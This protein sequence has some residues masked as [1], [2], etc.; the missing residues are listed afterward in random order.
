MKRLKGLAI[1]LVGL[2]VFAACQ[3]EF[4]YENPVPDIAAEGTLQG[5]AG[6]CTP[7]VVNGVYKND[8]TLSDS[9][10]VEVQINITSPGRYII[11]TDLQNGFAF[12]DSGFIADTGLH[13]FTLKA[14]GKPVL[15]QT[16]NFVV[17]FDSTICLFSVPVI[18]SASATY[19]LPGSPTACSNAIA[20]G[21]YTAGAAL[22]A[23]NKVN[24]QVNVVIPGS[25]SINTGSSNGMTF[26]GS[27]NFTTTGLQT[28]VLQGSG[29]APAAG[30]YTI[31][32]TA[33]STNCSFNITVTGSGGGTTNPNISDTA[34]SFTQGAN[35]FKGP[36]FDVFDTTQ[37]GL[38]YGVVFIGYTPAT[39][40]TLLQIGVLFSGGTIQPGTYNTN[41]ISSAFYFNDIADTANVN[42]I[43]TADAS[44]PPANMQ[45]TISSYDQTTG[46][47]TGTFTGTALNTLNAP[48]PITLGRFRGKVR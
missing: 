27:G 20:E 26:S 8:S 2:F 13:V 17:S 37:L 25:Y 42:D 34:W 15:A 18:G 3:K 9:N 41:T 31:P 10:N 48:V 45:I 12:R 16:T 6:N 36:F 47:I 39:A 23:T 29:R 46:I 4:S 14:L 30:V 44:T 21:I 7:I 22:S 43:Y 33:G 1:V 38:G 11:A 32:V 28:V 5:I 24:L 40:D 19:T 35:S